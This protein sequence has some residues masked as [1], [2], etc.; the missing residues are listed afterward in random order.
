MAANVVVHLVDRQHAQLLA[1]ASIP[2]AAGSVASRLLSPLV[3]APA[4]RRGI[5]RRRDQCAEVSFRLE[6][7]A[8]LVVFSTA[9]GRVR[10][11]ACEAPRLRDP[12][13]RRFRLKVAPASDP[14]RPGAG[15]Y[16]LATHDA[17]TA[18]RIAAV[19]N[20]APGACQ[21]NVTH[22]GWL[23]D[24]G[25]QLAQAGAAVSWRAIHLR[26]DGGQLSTL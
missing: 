11:L 21:N 22:S 20:Q 13:E 19:L 26:G 25:G 24:L 16:V 2:S 17:A 5:C 9:G 10:S 6:Q 7:E 3:A 12:G 23:A 14:G 4:E 15:F 18:Q 8:Y 1:S